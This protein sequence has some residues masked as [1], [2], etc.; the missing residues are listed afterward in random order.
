[1][2]NPRVEVLQLVKRWVRISDGA[3]VTFCK[4]GLEGII[5]WLTELTVGQPQS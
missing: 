2:A 3:Q 1:M 4:D 5:D